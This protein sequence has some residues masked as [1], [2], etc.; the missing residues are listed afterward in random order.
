VDQV[1]VVLLTA[2]SAVGLLVVVSIGLAVIF[3]LMGIINLAHG[4]FLMLGAYAQ[5]TLV[6]AGV[7]F[8]LGLPISAIIVGLMGLVFE[9]LLIRFL[10][11][12]LIDT[13]LATWGLSLILVQVAVLIFGPT[14]EGFSP[15]LGTIHIGNGSLPT[16][17]LVIIAFAVAM[18]AVTYWILTRTR[19]GV[20]AR[21]ASQVPAMADA[22]GINAGR[23][24]MYTFG[25]GA[26]LSGLAGAVITPLTAVV[27]TMG[28][29][30]VASAFMTV[31]VGGFLPVTGVVSAGT[32]LGSVSSVA[33][34]LTN[35]LLGQT[36]LLVVAVAVL[37]VFPKGL[38]SKWSTR[39]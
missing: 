23:I 5:L 30:Y 33:T 26:A 12:R 25:M 3:G 11:G 24:N 8:W 32:L 14:S 21:A 13:M 39:L 27:P 29:G 37:R 28:A 4:E 16:Y 35:T 18:C 9:R 17:R 20:L 15:P 6:K 31:L 38:S 34:S 19:Y 7:N 22:I 1:A 2:L 36:A 10:Y